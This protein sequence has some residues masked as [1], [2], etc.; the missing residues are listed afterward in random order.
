MLVCCFSYAKSLPFR[1]F[2]IWELFFFFFE[3]VSGV[4]LSFS[5]RRFLCNVLVDVV[6]GHESHGVH[7]CYKCG[8][9]FPNPHPSAK[10]RRAH[11]KICGTIEGYKLFVSE[12]QTHLNGSDDEHV[13]D[14]D[15]KTPGEFPSY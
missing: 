11:K 5:R 7:V 6:E 10:Q 3:I 1:V 13:S 4:F 2:V 8:W 14:E 9:S 12:G 15:H